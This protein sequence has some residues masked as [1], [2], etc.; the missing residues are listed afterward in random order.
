MEINAIKTVKVNAKTLHVFMK[1]CDEFAADLTDTEGVVL[2]EYE[3]YV[4]DFM[5]GNDSDYLDLVIDI[6]TGHILNWTTPTSR[7]VEAFISGGDDD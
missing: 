5:P 2:K 3:G 7:Q 1:V 6:D 4:P